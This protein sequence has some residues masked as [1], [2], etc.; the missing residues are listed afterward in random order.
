ME[1]SKR[2]IA[3]LEGMKGLEVP[4]RPLR[5][6]EISFAQFAV[7]TGVARNPNCTLT[8][9]AEELG[10]SA[11]SVSVAIQKLEKGE[12]ILRQQDAYD[13]RII[14]LQ[15]SAKGKRMML[16][17][18]KRRSDIVDGFLGELNKKEQEQLL[19]LLEKASQGFRSK[20]EIIKEN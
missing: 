14:R 7:L 12:W 6:A 5:N 8:E 2:L 1:N 15:L 4:R 10:L 11:P 3:I 16:S 9:L 19:G 17:M 18:V 13:A 20:Q